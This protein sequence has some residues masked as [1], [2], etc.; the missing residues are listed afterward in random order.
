MVLMLG[1]ELGK[2]IRVACV[3]GTKEEHDLE[4]GWNGHRRLGQSPQMTLKLRTNLVDTLLDALS[5]VKKGKNGS[6]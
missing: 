3:D 1:S 4:D 6:E 5:V 2:E